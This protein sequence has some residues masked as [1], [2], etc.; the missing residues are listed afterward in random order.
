MKSALLSRPYYDDKG[1]DSNIFDDQHRMYGVFDGMG[2]SEGARGA[3]ALVANLFFKRRADGYDAV[4]LGGLI[5]E[6]SKSIAVHFPNDGTTATVARVD[7]AGIL[8]FAHVGDSRL[9]VLKDGRVKQVTADEGIGNR[10]L[11]YC[12]PY[13]HGCVQ[14][15]MLDA[16]E[17]DSFMLCS[18]GITGDWKEQKLS[19]KLIEDILTNP[20]MDVAKMCFALE[21]ESKKDDDKT[22]IVVAKH[23]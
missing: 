23:E 10:L 5:D 4:Q 17:W 11:N 8:H 2:V 18:D 3:S 12:G 20:E 15:G 21:K 19:D 14:I 1:F 7:S 22:V 6:A 9:Y 16:D 13:T